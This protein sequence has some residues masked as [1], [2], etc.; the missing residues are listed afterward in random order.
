MMTDED[1][2]RRGLRE[3]PMSKSTTWVSAQ[4]RACDADQRLTWGCPGANTLLAYFH[5]CNKAIYPFS[6]E[7]K[8]QD[9]Q[10]LAEL[11]DDAISF[12]HYTRRVAAKQ[13]EFEPGVDHPGDSLLISLSQNPDGKN[14]GLAMT[15]STSST[16]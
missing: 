9:L 2:H 12:V 6:A 14:F 8:D 7:C 13:S 16:T 5:Y 15:T 10:S 11:D 1:D 3:R 4:Q